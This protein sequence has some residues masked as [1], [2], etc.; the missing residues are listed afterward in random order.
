[1]LGHAQEEG[2]ERGALAAYLDRYAGGL[3]GLVRDARARR[4]PERAPRA[5]VTETIDQW[6]RAAPALVLEHEAGDAEFVVLIAR[7]MEGGRIGVV[8]QADVDAALAGKLAQK[9]LPFA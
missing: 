4:R 5:A 6:R 1:V 7:A 3:K 8:A 9:A 2:V